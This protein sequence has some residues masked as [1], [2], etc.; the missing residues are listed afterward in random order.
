MRYLLLTTLL[1]STLMLRAETTVTPVDRMALA[2]QAQHEGD[3][4]AAELHLT[5]LQELA[6][7][8]PRVQTMLADVEAGKQADL[9]NLVELESRQL[10]P[11]GPEVR[12]TPR[13]SPMP[14]ATPAPEPEPP[15][16]VVPAADGARWSTRARLLDRVEDSWQWPQS[17]QRLAEPRPTP[18]TK[19]LRERLDT[20]T[21]PRVNFTAMPL[22]R[23]LD[24]LSTM[25]EDF[26]PAGGVNL[27]LMDPGGDDPE[28]TI[29]L[30]GLSLARVLDLAAGSVGYEYDVQPDAVVVRPRV[31]PGTNLE[32][33]FFPLNRS[34]LIRLIGVPESELAGEPIDPFAP[35]PTGDASA[36]SRRLREQ[37][38]A[39][40][41]FLQRAGV[42]FE[43]VDGANL[44]LADG[45]MIVT[46]TPRN[47]ERVRN[48]LRRYREV[49]QV[50]IEARFIEVQ[51]G[52][53]DELGFN[54]QVNSG[55]DTYQSANRRLSQSLSPSSAG[56]ALRITGPS[57][58]ATG[59]LSVPQDAP[60]LAREIDLGSEVSQPLAD[61]SGVLGGAQV[62]LLIRAL[63]RQTGNDLLSAP[64]VTVLSGKTAEIVVAQEL[65]YPQN[66]GDLDAQVGRG[67]SDAGSAGVAI[68]TGTPRDFT[69]RNV[70]VEMAVTPT[71][72]EDDSI[73]LLLEPQVTEFEGFVEYGGTSVAL[74]SGNTVTVPSGFYQP[75]FSVR[76]V[77][78]EVTIWDG[79]TVVMGGLTREQA[80]KIEDKVPLLG[81]IPLVGRLFRS[82]GESTQKRNLLIFVSARL[83]D[84]GGGE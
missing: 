47:L 43:G 33:A 30:R 57:A 80:V 14:V 83:V 39:L 40:Q 68:T 42:P 72:E 64:K 53:M 65:R 52:Q 28:V 69:T 50:E 7:D 49:K 11:S 55:A 38:A 3:W 74:S 24:T 27:V 15:V 19:A 46:Q 9:L 13:S 2:L 31:G 63:E 1:L 59:E 84:P 77:K 73:S 76:K 12:S 60:Q 62:Q 32:T 67:D 36:P 75:I 41:A 51:Q 21:L 4:E 81:D 61:V 78:T 16:E 79:A 70:G 17:E 8:D 66:F 48:L 26:D 10:E 54:W 82:E 22:S 34:T 20:I 25:S 29:T 18:E 71:V 37:E 44:A 45:Q 6:P 58:G 35:A 23:V 56:N 5:K